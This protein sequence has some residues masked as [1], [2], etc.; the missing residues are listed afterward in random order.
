ME[1]KYLKNSLCAIFCVLLLLVFAA[2]KED[3]KKT[4]PE[5]ETASEETEETLSGEP[6]GGATEIAAGTAEPD[7]SA[8][9]ETKGEDETDKSE[10]TTTES[11]ASNTGS[12]YPFDMYETPTYYSYLTGKKCTR[13]EQ[14]KRPVAIMI[15]NIRQAM[16]NVG[17]S[18]A[19]IV[20]ECMVEG[21][22]TRLMM[23]LSDYEDVPVFGSVRSSR[24][25]FI[26]LSRTHDAIYIHAGGSPQAYEQFALRPMIDRMDGVNMYFPNTFYRDAER[27]KTMAVEHT[28]MTSGAGIVKGIE[29]QSYRT[30]LQPEY[31]GAFGFNEEFTDVGGENNTANYMCVPYSNAFKAEFI[32][33]E[34]EKLY[35]RKQYGVAH[36][37]GATGEQIKFENVI[38]LFADYSLLDEKGRWSCDLTGNGYGFQVTGGRYKVIKWQ[39]D[40]REGA[41]ALYNTDNTKL[42]L[43]PGKSFVCITSK[44]YNKSV[45]INADKK[46]VN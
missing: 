9:K 39:K 10:E 44:A 34:D 26:D 2:C 38:V 29:Q 21:G 28:L 14:R 25:Y 11:K 37:D 42:L 23:V 30:T 6:G 5:S 32:Y 46:D 20:Y 18:K 15:N 7:T 19:D 1:S 16:P 41:L 17:I 33:K 43:N 13:K 8:E 35:Y 3:D 24:E 40:T 4:E 45:V 27:R 22:I 31:K 36:I 12:G